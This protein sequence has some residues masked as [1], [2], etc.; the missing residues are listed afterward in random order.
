MTLNYGM[1]GTPEIHLEVLKIMCGDPTGKAVVDLMCCE[2]S[3]T[4]KLYGWKKE[5]Y[6]DIQKRDLGAEKNPFFELCD[7][8]EYVESSRVLFFDIAICL[9]GIE[10]LSKKDGQYLME[11]L[12]YKV[13][14]AIFFTPLGSYMVE[15]DESEKHPDKHYSGWTP[16][17][18]EVAGYNCIVFHNFHEAL[19]CG[20]FFAVHS[21]DKT[22]WDR[23]LTEI[24]KVSWTEYS[25]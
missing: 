1:P 21:K 3:Q 25:K 16:Q 20:A 13:D 18:F 24:N 10:H 22:E 7:V 9:D 15:S 6:V 14:K 2:A 8:I 17:E 12:A 4:R 19:H 5:L 11:A 23:I